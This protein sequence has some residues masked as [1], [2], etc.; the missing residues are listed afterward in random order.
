MCGDSLLLQL[1][2]RPLLL[3]LLLLLLPPPPP[4]PL[5]LLLLLLLHAAF[6]RSGSGTGGKE[7]RILY[8]GS[9]GV[10]VP[11]RLPLQCLVRPCAH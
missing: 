10:L 2:L 4:P 1:Q 7:V 9:P 8:G 11:P 3:L 5:L 6:S